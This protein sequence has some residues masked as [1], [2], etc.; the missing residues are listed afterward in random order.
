MSQ[1]ITRLDEQARRQAYTC[2]CQGIC[3]VNRDHGQIR[4]AF[5]RKYDGPDL[6]AVRIDRKWRSI[7]KQVKA[8]RY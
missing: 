3:G 2:N 1:V 6:D 8:G 7:G 5:V 4:E